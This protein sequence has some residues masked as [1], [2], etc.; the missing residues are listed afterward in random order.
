MNEE[1][2]IEPKPDESAEAKPEKEQVVGFG[3]V[4]NSTNHDLAMSRLWVSDNMIENAEIRIIGSDC[5]KQQAEQLVT[6][7]KGKSVPDVEFLVEFNPDDIP[8]L[9]CLNLN[10]IYESIIKALVDLRKSPEEPDKT[11]PVVATPITETPVTE[12]PVA[13]T[14]VAETPVAETPVAETPVVESP[15]AENPP[16][17]KPVGEEGQ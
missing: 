16:E 9:E 12:T 13:E 10:I 11:E 8:D 15:P 1:Q 17:E 4:G 5:I 6:Q 7:I 2:T 3:I 14:P